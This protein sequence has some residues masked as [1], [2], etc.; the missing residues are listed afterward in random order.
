M[1]VQFLVSLAIIKS[2]RTAEAGERERNFI[3]YI[4]TLAL[5]VTDSL[6]Y[7]TSILCS[8]KN[9]TNKIQK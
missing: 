8:H 4:L 3:F 1:Y 5:L 7:K 2:L 6:S 9:S